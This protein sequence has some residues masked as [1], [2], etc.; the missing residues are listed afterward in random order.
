[1]YSISLK[2]LGSYWPVGNLIVRKNCTTE[3]ACISSKSLASVSGLDASNTI[4]LIASSRLSM[5]LMSL[6]GAVSFNHRSYSP[7]FSSIHENLKLL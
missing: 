6:A 2:L 7:W 4:K 5:R 1:M 3:I